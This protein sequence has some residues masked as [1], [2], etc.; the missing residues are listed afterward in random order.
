MVNEIDTTTFDL[1]G[2]H[3]DIGVAIGR[4]SQPFSLPAWWPEPPP[5]PYAEA[6]A[7]EISALHPLLLDEIHGHADGQKQSYAEI[8]R[9]ICRQRLGGRSLMAPVVSSSPVIPEH[10]GC[11]SVAW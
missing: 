4:G 10:G 5:L 1:E 9:I 2:T 11:T 3:Y 8:L 7:R 6:C